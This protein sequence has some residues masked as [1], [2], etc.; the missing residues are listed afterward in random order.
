MKL[1]GSV[2]RVTDNDIRLN[3]LIESK[4]PLSNDENNSG[5]IS[6]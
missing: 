5:N 1:Q 2:G 4:E 6:S 3:Q